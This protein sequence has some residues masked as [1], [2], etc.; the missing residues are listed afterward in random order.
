M[1]IGKSLNNS[2]AR[3]DDKYSTPRD[4]VY[5]IVKF[6]DNYWSPGDSVLD[7]SAGDKRFYDAFPNTLERHYCEIDE[8]IDF[9]KHDDQVDW[10]VGNPPFSNARN[11]W[12]HC[13]K[14]ARKGVFFI[15]PI[16]TA[17]FRHIKESSI[18]G[19]V[20]DH[21]FK[22][23]MFHALSVKEWFGFPVFLVFIVKD[24]ERTIPKFKTIYHIDRND[25]MSNE[26]HENSNWKIN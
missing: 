23:E 3:K 10:I 6:M 9:L 17:L 1:V 8:G 20:Y 15:Q 11:W 13:F 5:D 25:L 16:H 21:G 18:H 14:I 4:L 22:L 2:T 24:K 12:R 26:K 19:F 7:P